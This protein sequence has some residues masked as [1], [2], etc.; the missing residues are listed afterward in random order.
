M[1][2]LIAVGLVIFL[3]GCTLWKF[4]GVEANTDITGSVQ[5]RCSINTD[6]AGYYGNPSAHTLSTTAS[7]GGQEPIVRVDNSLANAFYVRLGHPTSFS[8]SPSL[9][10]STA[11]SGAVT[12]VQVSES[13]MDGYQNA[14]TLS[15]NVRQYALTVAGTTWFKITSQAVYG[16]GQSKP[17][18]SGQYTAVVVAECIAQ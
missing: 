1:K 18:P 4:G 13:G 17:F 9:A 15:N 12:V 6:T 14:S 8:S 5:S 2:K 7:D 3:S 11:F 10:D 16:G